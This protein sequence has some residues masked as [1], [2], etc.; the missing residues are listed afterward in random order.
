VRR[1]VHPGREAPLGA[2]AERLEACIDTTEII[3]P[4]A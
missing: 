3:D 2:D 1:G 4:E